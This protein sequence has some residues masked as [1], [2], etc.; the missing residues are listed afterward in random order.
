MPD[1]EATVMEKCDQVMKRYDPKSSPWDLSKVRC[2]LFLFMTKSYKCFFP[3]VWRK[4]LWKQGL[5]VCFRREAKKVQP[6]WTLWLL[7]CRKEG[8]QWAW[9]LP[10]WFYRCPGV[11]DGGDYSEPINEVFAFEGQ[12]PGFFTIGFIN[13]EWKTWHIQM[14]FGK[15]SASGQA[16]QKNHKEYDK[17]KKISNWGTRERL[18]L[19]HWLV[20]PVRI[21]QARWFSAYVIPRRDMSGVGFIGSVESTQARP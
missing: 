9:L 2:L 1:G 12:G 4:Q 15:Y 14:K 7:P 10:L 18:G 8:E 21:R 6:P 20:S 5:M 17:K 19:I 3:L 13:M 16:R 11:I